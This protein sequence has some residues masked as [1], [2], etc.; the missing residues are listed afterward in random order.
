[1]ENEII[2]NFE[3]YITSINDPLHFGGA[4]TCS[5]SL[6]DQYETFLILNA[7]H[8]VTGIPWSEHKFEAEKQSAIALAEFSAQ[9]DED[10]NDEYSHDENPEHGFM[11]ENSYVSEDQYREINKNEG[12]LDL[13][14][15]SN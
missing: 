5:V 8:H 4:L 11:L 14:D 13:N 6:E 1:V 7:E 9:D 2:F 12:T 15:E 10:E 3:A